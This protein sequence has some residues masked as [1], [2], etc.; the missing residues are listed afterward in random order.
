MPV[1]KAH[2]YL[3]KN[4]PN[5]HT[6]STYMSLF[7]DLLTIFSDSSLINH[8][9]VF[10]L[11]QLSLYKLSKAF[12]TC[13]RNA[14]LEMLFVHLC[15]IYSLNVQLLKTLLVAI[16]DLRPFVRENIRPCYECCRL[17]I[18]ILGHLFE[19]ANQ[20]SKVEHV[21]SIFFSLL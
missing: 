14:P 20:T 7:R 18:N 16:K 2:E 4:D 3:A 21:H 1:R 15:E 5:I 17:I 19:M 10:N 8:S 13:S 9:E 12:E 11:L 6:A